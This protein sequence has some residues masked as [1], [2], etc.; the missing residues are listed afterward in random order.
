M[1]L[2]L[3][4]DEIND[5]W[6]QDSKLDRTD[7]D[8]EL[9]RVPTLHSKYLRAL[10]QSKLKR[11][12]LSLAIKSLTKVLRRYYQGLM[13]QTELAERGWQQ[14]NN[15]LKSMEIQEYIDT[16]DDITKFSIKRDY[17]DVVIFQLETILKELNQRTW[18]IR[19][20]VDW[21]KFTNV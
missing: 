8:L 19:S 9:M 18:Q 7:P 14:F 20:I 1:E 5:A 6:E 2:K 12:S 16:N 17:I 15:S 10:T 21:R 3:N 11:Q 13:D 4:L